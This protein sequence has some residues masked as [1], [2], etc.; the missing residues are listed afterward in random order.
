MGEYVRSDDVDMAIRIMLESFI[1]T[2]K[3]S[4]QAALK[5]HFKQYLNYDKDTNQ[6]LLHLL[7]EEIDEELKWKQ[8][9]SRKGNLDS[10]QDADENVQSVEIQLKDFEQRIAAMSIPNENLQKFLK[11]KKFKDRGF[12]YDTKK[13]VIIKY[14]S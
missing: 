1:D 10:Q 5:K 13:K 14:L 11:S 7:N 8:I 9:T 12:K 6:L 3:K 2:Q 4:I